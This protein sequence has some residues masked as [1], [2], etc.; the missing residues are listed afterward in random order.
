LAKKGVD[1]RTRAHE[2]D[3][4]VSPPRLLRMQ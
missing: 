1:L 4:G 3:L 2:L